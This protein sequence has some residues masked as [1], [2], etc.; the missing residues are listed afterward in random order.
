MTTRPANHTRALRTNGDQRRDRFST[1]AT[2]SR[3]R[4]TALDGDVTM[5]IRL[6]AAQLI[7]Q[8]NRFI[9]GLGLQGQL[10]EAVL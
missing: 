5:S 2:S 1:M 8:S 3:Q 6:G 9:T 4:L 10:A 7:R